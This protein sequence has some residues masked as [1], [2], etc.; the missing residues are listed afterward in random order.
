MRTAVTLVIAA[1]LGAALG[2]AGVEGLRAQQEEKHATTANVLLRTDIACPT[3]SE[4]EMTL[5]TSPPGDGFP[6]HFHYGDEFAYVMQGSIDVNI[7]GVGDKSLKAGDAVQVK[8]GAA[9]VG[10]VTG[11]VPLKLLVIAIND[12][13]KPPYELVK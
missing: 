4:L 1:A 12:K 13:T 9:H 3:A 2:V 8:R 6:A 10:K 5:I 11:D 7:A